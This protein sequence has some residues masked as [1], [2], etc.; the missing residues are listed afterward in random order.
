MSHHG[1][2]TTAVREVA[3]TSWSLRVYDMLLWDS[4]LN[5]RRPFSAARLLQPTTAL[6]QLMQRQPCTLGNLQAK[7][8]IFNLRVDL[9]CATASLTTMQI[10]SLTTMQIFSYQGATNRTRLLRPYGNYRGQNHYHINVD[11][12]IGAM[13][14][15]HLPVFL[16]T[17]D[18][19]AIFALLKAPKCTIPTLAPH[20]PRPQCAS[21]YDAYA[22]ARVVGV[23]FV[24][25]VKRNGQLTHE[26]RS[27][28]ADIYYNQRFIVRHR[29][30]IRASICVVVGLFDL[31]CF[32][33]G[34]ACLETR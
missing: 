13:M 20:S 5:W 14:K 30:C 33:K 24:T 29:S 22:A 8:W 1:T 6:I 12:S 25:D 27:F 26:S 4:C 21:D 11:C 3:L 23:F 9:I 19:A 15:H 18:V 28:D 7:I 32:E 2:W 10:V 17:H 31:G 16:F 34:A